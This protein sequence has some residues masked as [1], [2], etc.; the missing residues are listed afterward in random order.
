MSTDA[1]GLGP[2][3]VGLLTVVNGVG[4]ACTGNVRRYEQIKMLRDGE[5]KLYDQDALDAAVAAEREHLLSE[6]RRMHDEQADRS[7][8]HNYY[9]YAANVLA[10]KIL[11]QGEA[12]STLPLVTLDQA[13]AMVAAARERCAAMLERDIDLGGLSDSPAWQKYTADLL[14]ACAA[15]LREPSAPA[16]AAGCAPGEG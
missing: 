6:L 11:P 2:L 12:P 13:E 7:V 5:H 16:Q 15:M 1:D 14:T 4:V 10:G 9:L 8:R 3:P